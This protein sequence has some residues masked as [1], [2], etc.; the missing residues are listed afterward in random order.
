[1]KSKIKDVGKVFSFIA[2]GM[3]IKRR[4]YEEIAVPTALYMAETWSIE[5]AR[6]K[7]LNA[8]EMRC[9]RSMCGVIHMN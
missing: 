5:V 7:R 2:L 1:M 8:M 9:L 3:N 4:M 6:K